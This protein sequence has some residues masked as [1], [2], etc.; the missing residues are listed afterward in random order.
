MI[1]ELLLIYKRNHAYLNRVLNRYHGYYNK[2]DK[3]R[4][5]TRDNADNQSDVCLFGLRSLISLRCRLT[6]SYALLIG[7]LLVLL[8]VRLRRPL[9][10]L[11]WLLRS[12]R[13]LLNGRLSV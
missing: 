6:R 3:Q 9:C 11:I 2:D 1:V 13:L 12:L 5:G 7:M 8:T 10:G 4:N